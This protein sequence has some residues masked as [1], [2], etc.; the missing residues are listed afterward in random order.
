[1]NTSTA[2]VQAIA[3]TTG[4]IITDSVP[5]LEYMFGIFMVGLVLLFLM[6]NFRSMTRNVFR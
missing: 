6:R 5:L 1:M 3:T 2:I 4:Q